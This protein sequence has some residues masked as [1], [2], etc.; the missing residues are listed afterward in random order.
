MQYVLLY[1]TLQPIFPIENVLDFRLDNARCRK[2]DRPNE[3]PNR[4]SA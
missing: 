1:P 3:P 4:A 2:G